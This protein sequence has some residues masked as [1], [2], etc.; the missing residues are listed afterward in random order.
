[1]YDS[2]NTADKAYR[3]SAK[4]VGDVMGNFHPHGDSSI[5][6][7]MVR[8]AQPWKMSHMLV[9]G[10]GNWGSIDDDPPAAM[11]YTEARLSK[12][13]A[14]LLRDIEKNTVPFKDNFDNTVKEP[15]VLPSRYP[16]LLVNGVSGIS[17]GFATEIP[18]H[19]LS[20]VIDAC[21]A[22]M[23]QPDISLDEL[24]KIVQGPDFP[25]GG[26]IMGE[27][28]IREAYTT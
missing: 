12:I 24:L 6:E 18:P 3:K 10:H 23:D 9:D 20:E 21:V 15:I 13:A 5:Y 7:G 17:S 28:G 14:Q 2:G 25:T 8:M 16:N 27:D 11:R 19:S 22:I 4:T 1:M 26:T